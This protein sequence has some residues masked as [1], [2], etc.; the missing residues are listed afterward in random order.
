MFGEEFLTFN[1]FPNGYERI[2]R[3]RKNLRIIMNFIMH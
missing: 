2:M 3:L 1:K